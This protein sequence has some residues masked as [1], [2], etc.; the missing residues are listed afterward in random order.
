MMCYEIVHLNL[1]NFGSQCHLNK[2][3]KKEKCFKNADINIYEQIFVWAY[4][5]I[6]LGSILIWKDYMLVG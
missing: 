5:F 4:A 3:N 1:Y 6:S 2:W